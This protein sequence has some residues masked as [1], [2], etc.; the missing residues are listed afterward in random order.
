MS[1]PATVYVVHPDP[2]VR[3][4]VRAL[5]DSMQVNCLS[6]AAPREFLDEEVKRPFGCLLTVAPGPERNGVDL[7]DELRH[8]RDS[9][10]VI[11][12]SPRADPS[13]EVKALRGGAI[14]FLVNPDGRILESAI[15]RGL[16][17]AEKLWRRRRWR[18]QARQEC[19]EVQR[20][21]EQL[22]AGETD[23][24]NLVVQGELNK[25]IARQLDVSIRTV[26]QRR[27]NIMLKM[28]AES[29][30]QLVQ[31]TTRLNLLREILE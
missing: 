20:K 3:S 11:M 4:S 19:D 15:R 2:Q 25:T 13:T 5:A 27:R 23:V 17:A 24:L 26:E 9:F 1:G 30:P 14:E 10:S 12:T 29:L 18:E 7:L 28:E 22:T 21:L 16:E 6:F 8:C 31:Q